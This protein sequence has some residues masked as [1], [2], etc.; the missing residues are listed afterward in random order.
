MDIR[1][2]PINHWQELQKSLFRQVQLTKDFGNNG[3]D[4]FVK[5]AVQGAV[6]NWKPDEWDHHPFSVEKE[7]EYELFETQR[8]I[9]VR[10]KCA[11]QSFEDSFRLFANSKKLKI[12]HSGNSQEIN[13]PSDVNPAAAY[14]RMDGDVMEIRLPKIR[15]AEPFQEIFLRK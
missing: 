3:I 6:R 12:E 14:A 15:N 13:L 10:C 4:Q 8:T 7:F 1:Q 11:D 5:K 2:N 9:F